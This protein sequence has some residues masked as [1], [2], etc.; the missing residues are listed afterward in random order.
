[1]IHLK[2][3]L[4]SGNLSDMIML[5]EKKLNSIH[6]FISCVYVYV[7][8]CVQLFVTPRTV[9]C[10]ALLSMRFFQARIPEFVTPVSCIGRQIIY[11]WV[12]WKAFVYLELTVYDLP[13]HPRQK[14]KKA[15]KK[16]KNRIPLNKKLSDNF[17]LLHF[18]NQHW[19]LG[20]FFF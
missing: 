11:H 10:Q 14:K 8:S 1:M 7:P 15:N 18:V 13:L 16:H 20:L 17:T 19:I 9:A 2:F 6:V 4:E 5:G 12:T 3:S